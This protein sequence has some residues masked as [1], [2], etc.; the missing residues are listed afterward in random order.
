MTDWAPS[1]TLAL[2]TH[3]HT[4]SNYAMGGMHRP[5]GPSSGPAVITWSANLAVY[6]PVAIP[7][8][9]PVARVFWLNGSTITTTNVDFGIYSAGGTR[10]YST[11]STAMSGASTIQ[12]VT[13]GTPFILPPGS[14]YF[15]WTCSSTTSRGNAMTFATALPA[16]M[17]GLLEQATALPLPA[18][19]TFAT[20]ATILGAP[21]C[22][23]TRTASGF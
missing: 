17:M 21:F 7:W 15:A 6:M 8:P 22:G 11:T 9:Y 3:V 14:Y 2:P 19:A 20:F 1:S 12:Y 5:V 4:M 23:I 16:K 18:T 10:I 13:P